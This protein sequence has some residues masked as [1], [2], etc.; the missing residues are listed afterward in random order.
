MLRCDDTAVSQRKGKWRGRICGPAPICF[1]VPAPL[2]LAGMASLCLAVLASMLSAIAVVRRIAVAIS[3]IGQIGAAWCIR[4]VSA[5]I[6]RAVARMRRIVSA[7]RRIA[8]AVGAADNYP[9]LRLAVSPIVRIS[10][11][12]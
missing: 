5:A 7:V 4:T 8:R 11:S 6:G 1:S 12:H 9:Y 3:S 10:R 2:V